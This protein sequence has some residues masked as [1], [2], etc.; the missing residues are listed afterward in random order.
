M[1]Q[2]TKI[3]DLIGTWDL[4]DWVS[5]K[6]GGFYTYPMGKDVKGQL[7]YT[8]EGRMSGFLMRADF[9]AQ[10]ART[11]AHAAICLSYGGTYRIEGDQVIHDVSL[12]TIPEWLNTPL[13]RTM[14]WQEEN[15]LLKTAPA[16]AK[17]GH[18]YSNE[19][20]WKKL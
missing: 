18:A 3:S 12:S 11:T 1:T 16:S 4:I 2:T 6:D 17:D 5:L 8:Q 10:P 15:L 19:L 9:E 13:I 14:A 20:L 7:I